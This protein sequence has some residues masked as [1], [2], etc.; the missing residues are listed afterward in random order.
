MKRCAVHFRV[1]QKQGC[2]ADEVDENTRDQRVE[3]YRQS[4]STLGQE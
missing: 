2:W 1:K 3:N 4:R